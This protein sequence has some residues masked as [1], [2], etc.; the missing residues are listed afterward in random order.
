MKNWP[1]VFV[2]G[3]AL[4]WGV[5]GNVSYAQSV[6]NRAIGK[7]NIALDDE[8]EAAK[9]RAKT[10]REMENLLKVAKEAGFTEEEFREITVER[11]GEKIN[12]WDFIQAEKAR[13][14]LAKKAQEEAAKKRYITVKDITEDLIQKESAQISKLRDNLLFSGEDEQ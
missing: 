10:L 7:T 6:L 11:D 2:L 8:T 1:S 5:S 14:A 9:Q 13:I 4:F 3:I 12:V